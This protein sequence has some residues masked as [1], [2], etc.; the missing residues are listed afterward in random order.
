MLGRNDQ[1]RLISLDVFRGLTIAAMVLVNNP[2]TSPVYWPLDHAEWNGLTPTDWIFPFFLFIVGVSIAIALGKYRSVDITGG[3]ATRG[4]REGIPSGVEAVREHAGTRSIYTKIIT[5]AVSIYLCGTAISVIP[6]FQFGATDAPDWLKMLTWLAFAGALLFLLLRNFKVAGTLVG[7]GI[8]GIVVMNAA[9]YNV[10]P[11]DFGTMRI[12]G[13][14]Q[15]I[16]VCYLISSLIFLHTNWKQQLYISGA[17]LLGYWFLI[18]MVP[19]P[20]CEVTTMND[21]ACNLAAYIDRIVLTENHIW[22]FGKV[23]DPEGL[24][25]TIPAIVTTISGI[26]TGTWLRSEPSA[27]ADGLSQHDVNSNVPL[28]DLQPP[29]TAGGSDKV[30]GILFSGTILLALGLIWNSYF[31]MNKALWTSS[32]V[33][34]TTGLALLTF[35]CCYWLIDIKGYKRWAWPFV[36]FGA[37]ALALFVFSGIFARM[38]SA[39]RVGSTPEGRGISVQRWL[40]DNI[41]LPLFQPIN[42]SLA[43]AISFILLWLF[44]MWLLYRKRIYIKV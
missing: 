33:L 24:L 38:M 34:A 31:P 42:A 20:G 2:G 17:L 11:Y 23:Y 7:I 21:K 8:L 29:A 12:M 1:N 18:T 32:Y 27:V 40:V 15:R 26:L 39:F 4:P 22:R 6:F 44:L 30:A 37:N 28:G 19:V 14:L 3:N 9:G 36:V 13:V 35:G 25:S 16:A 5:R 10:V 41:Y 43:Y